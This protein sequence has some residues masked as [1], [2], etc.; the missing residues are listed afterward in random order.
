[1]KM[2][3]MFKNQGGG[4]KVKIK[5]TKSE[6]GEKKKKKKT[7]TFNW[8]KNES[9]HRHYHHRRFACKDLKSS[10]TVPYTHHT[11]KSCTCG[12]TDLKDKCSR[13]LYNQIILY[14]YYR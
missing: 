7:G 4:K 12:N 11:H 8:S 2:C 6:M 1:M 10:S 9:N 13:I 5:S 3:S 14:E